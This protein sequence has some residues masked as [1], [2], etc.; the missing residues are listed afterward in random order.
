MVELQFVIQ[1][2]K[3]RIQKKC[4]RS[5]RFITVQVLR[6]KNLANAEWLQWLTS[7]FGTSN[8][9]NLESATQVEQ[10]E[11]NIHVAL[12]HISALSASLTI[13]NIK[14]YKIYIFNRLNE[15][16]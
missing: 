12:I 11:T 5:K 6:I 14:K 8:L 2:Y 13:S 7:T 3:F 1:I 4:I 15:D 10:Y 9:S 16:Y